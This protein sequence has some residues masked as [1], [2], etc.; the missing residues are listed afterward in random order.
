M[1][2]I[3]LERAAGRSE[4]EA[5]GQYLPACLALFLLGGDSAVSLQLKGTPCCLELIIAILHVISGGGGHFFTGRAASTLQEMP[6][7][8]MPTVFATAIK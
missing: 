5:G 3:S 2:L 1:L 8:L 6:I 4:V 7:S